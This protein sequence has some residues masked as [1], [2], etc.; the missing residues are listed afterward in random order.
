MTTGIVIVGAG[1]HA[2]VCIELLRAMK[3]PI[4]FCIGVDSERFCLDVPVLQGDEHLERLRLAGHTQ[5]FIAIGPNT[6]RQRLGA[7]ARALGYELVNAISPAA[8]VSPT[9]K[10]GT[11]IAVMAGAVINADAS[12]G[13]FAII[14]TSAS[15]DHDCRIGEGAHVAPHCA[16]VG[17]VILGP[18]V[19]L[20]VGC[21]VIPG[22]VIGAD[23]VAGAGSVVI[24]DVAPNTRIAGVPA[25]TIQTKDKDK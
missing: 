16:L 21:N 4:A 2:K 6:L 19:F 14:N 8:V 10:L 9:A 7:S 25:R 12:I 15:V 11:G 17:N 22:T 5:A 24:S 1:G 13:D 20:G 3:L 23:V 18:R